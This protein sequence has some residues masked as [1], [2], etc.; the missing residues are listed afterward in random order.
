[1]AMTKLA[2]N[3]YEPGFI[4]NRHTAH[5]CTG[6]EQLECCKWVLLHLGIEDQKPKSNE[7]VHIHMNCFTRSAVIDPT[8]S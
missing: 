7:S 2:K 3:K 5:T 1:M 8:C 6:A 4:D